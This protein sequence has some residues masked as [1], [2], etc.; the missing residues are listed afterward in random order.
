MRRCAVQRGSVMQL[1]VAAA[2]ANID[3][4]PPLVS[5]LVGLKGRDHGGDYGDEAQ[6]KRQR[7]RWQWGVYPRNV[8]Q[9]TTW[10]YSERKEGNKRTR[11]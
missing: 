6:K 2:S 1:L 8:L 10:S 3:Q 4:Q 5:G 9:R 11:R 7:Q